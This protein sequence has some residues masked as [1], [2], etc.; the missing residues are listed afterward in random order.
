MTEADYMRVH[1]A[2]GANTETEARGKHREA[3]EK[4]EEATTAFMS[5][6]HDYYYPVPPRTSFQRQ[7]EGGE[8]KILSS[9]F[10]FDITKEIQFSWRVKK[11]AQKYK[12]I[13]V[14]RSLLK[15]TSTPSSKS[16]IYKKERTMNSSL[17]IW[18]RYAKRTIW[19]LCPS[20]RRCKEVRDQPQRDRG[21]T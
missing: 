8:A 13:P 10:F 2:T 9:N 20:S 6:M 21:R 3:G 4:D 14:P 5:C 18:H 1:Q 19:W 16:L 12:Y 11:Y 15:V 7:E 17:I